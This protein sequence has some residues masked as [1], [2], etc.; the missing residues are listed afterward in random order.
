MT[1]AETFWTLLRDAP[2]WEFELFLMALVDGLI[3]G[4]GVRQFK[5]WH[6]THDREQHRVAPINDDGADD[7]GIP[8]DVSAPHIHAVGDPTQ[9]HVHTHRLA[10][11]EH[12]HARS[13]GRTYFKNPARRSQEKSMLTVDLGVADDWAYAPPRVWVDEQGAPL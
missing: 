4:V 6:R 2:H 3:V 5:R 1:S 7:P 12:R 10:M 8:E 11:L 13:T 9:V